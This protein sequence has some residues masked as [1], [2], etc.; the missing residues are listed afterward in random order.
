MGGGFNRQLLTGTVGIMMTEVEAALQETA[1]EWYALR[2]AVGFEKHALENLQER[3]DRYGMRISFGEILLPM[4]RRLEIRRKQK[5]EVEE[6]MFPGYLFI[7]MQMSAETWHLVRNTRWISGFIGG[8]PEHPRPLS[9]E[10]ISGIRERI[11]AGVDRSTLR[12][13]FITGEHVRIKEGPFGDFNGIVES[14]NGERERLVVSVMVF[15]RSTPVEL[16]FDQAEKI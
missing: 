16:D 2:V 7:E 5:Q 14:V 3:I 11:G 13:K 6:K 15:G 8:S 12:A 1:K 10:E 4:E 9:A